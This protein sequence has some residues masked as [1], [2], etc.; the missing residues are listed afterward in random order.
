MLLDAT[1]PSALKSNQA[2]R[3]TISSSLGDLT[4][5]QVQRSLCGTYHQTI[6]YGEGIESKQHGEK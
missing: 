1:N 3:N 4:D 5:L 2:S 6:S